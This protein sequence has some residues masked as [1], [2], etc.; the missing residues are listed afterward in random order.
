MDENGQSLVNNYDC[1]LLFLLFQTVTIIPPAVQ[2]AVSVMHECTNSCYFNK[3]NT[4]RHIER[5]DIDIIHFSY[6]YDWSNPFHFLNIYC[7][8]Q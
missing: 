3:Q 1:P 8:N 5:E 7:M 6:I 4:C 2:A